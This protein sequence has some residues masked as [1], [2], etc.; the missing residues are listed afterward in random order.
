[1]GMVYRV[2]EYTHPVPEI[3][4]EE[5]A[6]VEQELREAMTPPNPPEGFEP[7]WKRGL[8]TT[9]ILLRDSENYIR[10]LEKAVDDAAKETGK[11]YIAEA[12]AKLNQELEG[13]PKA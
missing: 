4:P 3:T 1:M 5:S 2:G 13:T 7:D 10:V 12:L 11:S 9:E 8:I 6:Q